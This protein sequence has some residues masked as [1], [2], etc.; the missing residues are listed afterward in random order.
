M[1][2]VEEE[3]ELLPCQKRRHNGDTS[4]E[5]VSCLSAPDCCVS[6]V[7]TAEVLD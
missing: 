2:D 7:G 3:Y 4:S 1:V 5:A 6:R